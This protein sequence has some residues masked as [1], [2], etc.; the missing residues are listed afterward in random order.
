MLPEAYDSGSRNYEQTRLIP[1]KSR[2]GKLS[3]TYSQFSRIGDE[4]SHF[5]ART[6]LCFLTNAPAGKYPLI[7]EPIAIFSA[8]PY[9]A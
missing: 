2:C 5:G 4:H 9:H 7:L 8:I 6:G 3:I 1:T